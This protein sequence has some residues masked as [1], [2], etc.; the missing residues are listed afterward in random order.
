VYDKGV[1]PASLADNLTQ[2]PMS[3]R[4]GDIV[5]PFTASDE[6]LSVQ[7]EHF[8]E[9]IL[10]GTTPRSNGMVGLRVVRVLEA[11]QRCIDEGGGSITLAELDTGVTSFASRTL[12]PSNVSGLA[13]MPSESGRALSVLDRPAMSADGVLQ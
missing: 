10:N 7:D 12:Y 2:P 3:Y 9:C 1:V 11:A 6:P 8:V 5:A 4:Y 13:P